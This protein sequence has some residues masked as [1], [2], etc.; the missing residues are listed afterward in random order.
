MTFEEFKSRKNELNELYVVVRKFDLREIIRGC[1]YNRVIS[2][3]KNKPN[4]YDIF[5]Y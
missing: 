3:V 2:L 1:N 5:I 4:Y